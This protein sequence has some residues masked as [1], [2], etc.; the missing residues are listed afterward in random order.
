MPRIA[1][2]YFKMN[3]GEMFFAIIKDSVKLLGLNHV[4]GIVHDK[5]VTST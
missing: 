1:N 2:K 5:N 4:I 3:D